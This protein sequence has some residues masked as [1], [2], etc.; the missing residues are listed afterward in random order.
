MMAVF[1][2]YLLI[3]L[4]TCMGSVA[5]IFFKRASGAG[6]IA[7]MIKDVDLWIG[8]GL[9]VISAVINIFVLRMLPYSV[10]LPLTALT[11]VWTMVFSRLLLHETLTVR[12]LAGVA[13]VFAGAVFVAM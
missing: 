1:L 12:K 3:A 13:C 4:M 10:V 8:G 5:S 7:A 9:Y 11:Y 2:P 6:G